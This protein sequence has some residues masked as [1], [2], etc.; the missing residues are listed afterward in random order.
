MGAYINFDLLDTAML[1]GIDI[2]RN[3]LF[4]E[5]AEARCPYCC[6]RRYRMYL[7]RLTNMFYCHNCGSG[8]NAVTLYADFNPR[9]LRLNNY[10]S[11]KALLNEPSVKR[12]DLPPI[13][14]KPEPPIRRLEE[15]SEIYSEFLG[16]L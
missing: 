16:L 9:G 15:R 1:C 3:T 8:G 13:E 4:A 6:D 11:Y 7:S 14:A 2:K 5:E 12:Y 10:E